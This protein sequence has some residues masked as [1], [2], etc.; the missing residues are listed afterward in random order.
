MDNHNFTQQQ[1][2]AF[3]K[4]LQGD[5]I[6][7]SGPG[8]SG[9]SF[10]IKEVVKHCRMVNKKHQVCALTGCAAMLLRCQAKTIHSWSGIGLAHGD[11]DRIVNKVTSN[12]MK[13]QKWKTTK[14]LIIDEVSMMS[15]RLFN[16]LDSLGKNIRK[17]SRKAFGGLQVIFC[18][19]FFQLP[20]INSGDDD[21]SEFCFQHPFFQETFPHQIEFTTIFRQLDP[22]Y[23]KILNQIRKGRISK[24]SVSILKKYVN[25]S[26]DPNCKIIPTRLC[27]RKKQVDK[28]NQEAMNKLESESFFFDVQQATIPNDELEPLYQRRM[29]EC[30]PEA[31]DYE[32]TYLLNNV[33]CSHHL[34]LK[35]GAQVMCVANLDVDSNDYPIG[36]GSL[37]IITEFTSNNL[38]VVSFRN[39]LIK[40]IGY[41]DWISEDW[42]GL[43][44]RQIPLI[45]SWAMT[46]HKSQG[47]CLEMAE[48]D[49]GSDIFE[50]GQSYVGLSRIVSLEGL[51]L[52]NFNPYKIRINL[53]VK[54]F[55]DHLWK[56][57]EVLDFNT[58]VST[59]DIKI[60][61]N[62]PSKKKKRWTF[63][64]DCWLLDNRSL[65]MAVL[66]EY[67][68]R[69]PNAIN[70]R[71]KNLE[72]PDHS[73]YQRFK[74]EQRKSVQLEQKEEILFEV[75]G[76]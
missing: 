11:V 10:F 58:S 30:S 39:G 6:F 21:D 26:R 2:Y 27:P 28:I 45:L 54:D 18:G 74:L 35:V 62:E 75:S 40:T 48:I 73:A 63:K 76:I 7:I 38:P 32:Y 49:L 14:V 19:D 29:E 4:Y 8:G 50:C 23:T 60:S 22:V 56:K 25:R 42:P 61:K 16:I 36:N 5:N 55:Y 51:Y 72:D 59:Q 12:K 9:K 64:D 13:S 70:C 71:L 69:T 44:I 52:T 31:K 41:H 57:Q 15:R 66:V 43:S 68:Q 33:N 20:P 34:E 37:G 1:Q 67:F 3:Q 47:S 65:S 46:I 53:A 24:N 17:C